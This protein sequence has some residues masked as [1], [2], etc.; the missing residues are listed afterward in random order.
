MGGVVLGDD[1]FGDTG[2]FGID[3]AGSPLC[4]VEPVTFCMSAG[5][6]PSFAIFRSMVFAFSSIFSLTKNDVA[7]RAIT[8][9]APEKILNHFTAV[10]CHV[11]LLQY[12]SFP[13]M[14]YSSAKEIDN[15]CAL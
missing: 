5:G 8:N 7:T 13:L 6:M 12:S 10:P 15:S 2:A 1:G 14:K 11:S 4:S 9:K 3:A